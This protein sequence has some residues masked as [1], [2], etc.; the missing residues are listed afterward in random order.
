MGASAK[1][2]SAT[3][4]VKVRPSLLG[5]LRR[6]LPFHKKVGRLTVIL[7][8][9]AGQNSPLL[10]TFNRVFH[11]AGYQWDIRLTN[12]FGDGQHHARQAIQEGVDIVAVY[13]GD[14]SI[15]DV[16]A[17]MLDSQVPLAILP[18][19]T[20]N[21]L[22]M[23]LNL[24]W[25]LREACALL[26]NPAHQVKSIDAALANDVCFMLRAGIGLD[27]IIV[28]EA[29]RDLVD[30]FGVVAYA[31]ATIEALNSCKPS[32]FHMAIDG[33]EFDIEGQSCMIANA[34]TLGVPGLMLSPNVSITDGL[35]DVFVIRKSDL[36]SLLA[37]ASRV[38]GRTEDPD[39]FPHWQGA[40]IKLTA[41]PP[42]DVEG[43]GELIGHTPVI[44][45]VK[46]GAIKVIVP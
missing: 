12:Q 27:A 5:R 1:D 19:G 9:A 39:I 36:G 28:K 40:E 23:E 35:L 15:M 22:A 16:A 44:V 34:A 13:G 43:D 30:R 37:L 3:L 31:M 18:G 11:E 14:G 21:A 8:P 10:K 25:P 17:G 6:V 29:D 33:K 38:V 41:D 20:G 32:N 4:P 45:R 2:P 24:P 26:V 7:N 42:V 46:P